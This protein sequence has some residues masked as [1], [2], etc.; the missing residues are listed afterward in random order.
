MNLPAASLSGL[1]EPR[2]FKKKLDAP[3]ETWAFDIKA[4]ATSTVDVQQPP[5]RKKVI[6]PIW[7][8]SGHSTAISLWMRMGESQ[9]GNMPAAWRQDRRCQIVRPLVVNSQRSVSVYAAPCDRT[10]RLAAQFY[11]SKGNAS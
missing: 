5:S 7:L 8:G 3:G 2:L 6:P 10:Q 1:P 11:T 4:A 9:S